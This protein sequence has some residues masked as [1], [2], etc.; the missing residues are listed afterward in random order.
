MIQHQ[1]AVHAALTLAALIG[2]PM[3][4]RC[5]AGQDRPAT[6]P[7]APPSPIPQAI[8]SN[9]PLVGAIVAAHNKIRA[10][11]KLPPLKFAP[12]LAQAAQIQATDMAEHDQMKHE[13]TD[14]STPSDRIRRVGY[15][16]Q[17]SGENVAMFY[18]DVEQ[19]MQ[20]WLDSPPHKK[21]ILGDFTELGVAR[22]D[23]KEGKPY[24]CIDFGTPIP[25]LD[26]A[27]AAVAFATK[28]NEARTTAKHPKLTV[29]PKLATAAQIQAAESAKTSGKDGTP[30]SFTGLDTSQYAE[31]AMSTATGPPTAEAVLKM[32]LDNPSYKD[33]LF[34]QVTK[35]GVGYATDPHGI[36]SWCLILG[37]PIRR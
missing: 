3:G 23:N 20:G 8:D 37:K 13:G 36:P 27:E 11:A 30:T 34:G 17:T 35:I 4:D 12:L 2:G 28:L 33:R 9:D 29:D 15:H 6:N 1:R 10:E 18:P 7:T 26:P 5:M 21:N 19:V 16:F 22:V 32:F 25:Q 31:L 14:G 24:W